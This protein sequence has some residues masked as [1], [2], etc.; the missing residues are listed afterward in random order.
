MPTS[1]D[2]IQ[3]KLYRR[4]RAVDSAFDRHLLS[5]H[6]SFKMDKF[7]LQEGLISNL[8]QSWCYFCREVVI[9]SALGA[10]TSTGIMTTSPYA[11]CS[12][13]EIAYVAKKLAN[14]EPVGRIRPL[15]G[16]HQEPTWGDPAK[17]GL[18][19]AGLGTS[20][21]GTLLTAF[22]V[23][24]RLN[25]LQLC[26]N[27]CAHVTGDMLNAVASAKVRYVDTKAQHPSDLMYWVDPQT[28]DYVWKSWVDEM[29][30]ASTFAVA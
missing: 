9:S 27:A 19:V 13:M 20:N 25:D 14:Q 11:T 3:R 17:I 21:K 1:L 18:V 29:E 10:P 2:S 23:F 12:E 22:G 15:V 5:P 24:H 16:S 28:N 30:L 8:W 6:V 4:L 26:R 7:S